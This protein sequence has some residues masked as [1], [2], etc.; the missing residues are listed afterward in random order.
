VERC[1]LDALDDQLGDAVATGEDHRFVGIQV[2]HADLD[3]PPKAGVNRTGSVDE[4]YPV[5]HG[6]AGPRMHERSM[7]IGQ[8]D[9]QTCWQQRTFSGLECG[10]LHRAQVDTCITGVGDTWQLGSLV[11]P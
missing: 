3:L 11:E 6:E 1:A 8:G 9:G 4:T 5:A 2:D 10:V 7:S